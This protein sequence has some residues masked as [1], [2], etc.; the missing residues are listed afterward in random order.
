MGLT[1]IVMISIN[2]SRFFFFARFSP[3]KFT[4]HAIASESYHLSILSLL[5]NVFNLLTGHVHIDYVLVSTLFA[6]DKLQLQLPLS[7]IKVNHFIRFE[8]KKK[9]NYQ[10]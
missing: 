5:D 9:E 8:N 6:S 10:D 3:S 2:F 4:I 1:V 7:K